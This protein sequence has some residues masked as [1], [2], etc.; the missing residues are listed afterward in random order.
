MS[1]DRKR[2]TKS[3]KSKRVILVAYEGDN[4]TEKDYF[5]NFSGRDKDYIIKSVPGNETD[6]VSLVRQTIKKVDDLALDLTDDD[7]A[8]CVFDTDIKKEKNKQIIDAI[9]LSKENSII[10]IVSAPCIELWFLL[11]YNY[12]TAQ[13]SSSNVIKKLE[14]YYPKYKKNCDIYKDIQDKTK[15]AIHN[16][17]KLEKYH[18]QNKKT[19]QMVETNQYTEVYKIVEELI[20]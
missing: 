18:Q 3:R 4:K 7:K 9:N 15:T 1:K 16:S 14:K 17:K 10:P 13:I 6:P 12:S 11:H 5:N 19:L 2:N 20:K 8:Y